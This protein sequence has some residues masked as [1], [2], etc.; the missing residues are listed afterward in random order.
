MHSGVRFRGGGGARNFH[1]L[2]RI[3]TGSGAH[4][5]SYPV[6]SG[7]LFRGVKRPGR[8]AD[9]AP[10]SSVEVK[11]CVELYLHPYPHPVRLHGVVPNW[12]TGTTLRLPPFTNYLSVNIWKWIRRCRISGFSFQVSRFGF[13]RLWPPNQQNI[14]RDKIDRYQYE[15]NVCIRIL[16]KCI[17]NLNTVS[18]HVLRLAY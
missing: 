15:E 3:H 16:G 18:L 8:G 9:H 14:M 2:H 1:L 7:G 11:E 6:G 12:T 5:A 17:G 13:L 10:H 4:R